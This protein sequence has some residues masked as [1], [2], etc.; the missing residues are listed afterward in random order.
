MN[1]H[2]FSFFRAIAKKI[3]QIKRKKGIN[4]QTYQMSRWTP[5]LKDSLEDIKFLPSN[6]FIVNTLY[7]ITLL[8]RSLG[9]SQENLADQA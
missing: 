7:W 1:Y 2:A 6:G 5:I 8:S 4:D 9:Q 3:W